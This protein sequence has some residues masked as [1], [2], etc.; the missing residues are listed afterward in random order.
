NAY[1]RLQHPQELTALGWGTS[2]TLVSIALTALL[3][4][5]QS[6]V[7]KRTHS[8]AVKA[9]SLHYRS[10]LATNAVILLALLFSY[11]GFQRVDPLFAIVI[12]F[13]ILYSA[14]SIAHDSVQILLDRELPD[15]MRARIIEV[16]EAIDEVKSI[17]DLRTRRSGLTHFIQL[18]IDLDASLTLQQAHRIA[19][20]VEA[21]IVAA[22]PNAD[23]II[24][25][26][27]K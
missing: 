19:D 22:I 4:L 23:V 27:P 9:D 6:Y 8:L 10:D 18:H 24:H 12:A 15:A 14:W 16:A 5:F 11:Y 21:A 7:V 3:L 25:Q 26:D 20:E 2:V 1:D 17:H 13:Y